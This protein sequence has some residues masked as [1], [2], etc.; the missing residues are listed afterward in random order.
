[1]EQALKLK[2]CPER[3]AAAPLADDRSWLCGRT[4][5]NSGPTGQ[6]LVTPA[7]VSIDAF[8]R[9]ARPPGAPQNWGERIKHVVVSSALTMAALSLPAISAVGGL[10]VWRDVAKGQQG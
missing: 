4:L 6:R 8:L 2:S 10:F 5:L 3:G 7:L 9:Q 1:M